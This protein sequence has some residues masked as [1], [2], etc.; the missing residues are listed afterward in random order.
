VWPDFRLLLAIAS[1]TESWTN[2][3]ASGVRVKSWWLFARAMACPMRF[4]T[5]RGDLILRVCGFVDGGAFTNSGVDLVNSQTTTRQWLA[6]GPAI[7]LTLR[8][9]SELFME[10]EPSLLFPVTRWTF[11]YKDTSTGPEQRLD[12]IRTVGEAVNFSLGYRFP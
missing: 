5:R 2:S 12:Q 4:G 7:R 8:L 10:A 6:A 3:V 11:T 9:S 1:T